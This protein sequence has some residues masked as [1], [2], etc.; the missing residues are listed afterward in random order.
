MIRLIALLLSAMALQTAFGQQTAPA[1]GGGGFATAAGLPGNLFNSAHKLA[2]STLKREWASIPMG[3]GTLRTLVI[4]PEGTTPAPVVLLLH[5]EAGLDSLQQA[6]AL[7][8]AERGY[9]AVAPDLL[10]GLGPDGG[11]HDSFRFPD[12]AMR[13]LATMKPA[14]AMRRYKIA[15]AYARSMPRSNGNIAAIGASLGGTHAFR[16]ASELPELRAAVVFYGLPPD[17]ASL[18]RIS[19]PVLGLYAGD[20]PAVNATIEPTASVMKQLGKSYESRTYPGATHFF[21]SYVVE[22]RNGDAVAAAWPAAMAFLGEH[23]P[24]AAR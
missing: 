13:T 5:Y 8:L 12:A 17:K 6:M 16:L 3:R 14:E 20:D 15:A 7:Q 1:Q 2:Q 21:L 11:N 10:S 19:A 9:L 4:H 23:N 18:G 24:P 22:G